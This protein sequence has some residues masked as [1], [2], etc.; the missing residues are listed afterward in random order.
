MKKWYADIIVDI[1]Q[2][3]LDRTFQYE[4]PQNLLG[5]IKT[6]TKVEVPFGK[7]SRTISGY[8]IGISDK[9][10]IEESK[11][12]PVSKIWEKGIEIESKLIGLAGWMSREY[13][14][15]MNQALKTVLP[16]KEKK[17]QKETRTI[18]L[19]IEPEEAK[20]LLEE[21][22]RKHYKAKARLLEA[23][24]LKGVLSY[25]EAT[26][27][28]KL[29]SAGIKKIEES[30]I[31]Q[32][33]KQKVYR[34]PV[35][36]KETKTVQKQLNEEQD[37]A[38]LE[39]L[40]EWES[41]FHRPVLLYGVTGSGKTEV[42]MKLIETI[43]REGKQAI[44]LIPEIALTYQT[45]ERFRAR[46]GECVSF[47]H[48]R[49]SAGERYDQMERAKNGEISIIVGPRSALFTPFPN[50]GLIVIDEEQESSYKSEKTPCYHARETAIERAR[51][52]KANVVMGSATPTIESYERARKG[53]YLLVTLKSRY[54]NQVMPD[55]TIVNLAEELK[56]GNRS[57]FSQSL[58][59]KIKERLEKKQQVMLFLNRRGYTGFVSCRACGHVMKCPHCDVSL[60]S[61]RNGKLICHYCGYTIPNVKECPSCGSPYIGGFKAGT[62]QIE[63]Q[64]HLF[65]PKARILRMDADTTR[66]KDDHEKILSA[67]LAQEADILIGT[68]MIVKGHDF[69]NVTLVGV[70]AADLSLNVGDY[71]ASERTFQ[72]LTQAVGRAGRGR[73]AGEAVIQ[74]Y[75]PEHY[76]IVTSA[77]Q[78][79]EQFFEQ[80][81]VY[82]SLMGYPPAKSML[83]ISGSSAEEALLL[84]G[85]TYCRK[86]IESIYK[87]NDLLIVG[88]APQSI[89]KI[90]DMYR[91]V[92]HLRH[93]NKEILIKIME[94][95]ERYIQI[96][97][98][99]EKIYIQFDMN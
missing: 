16:V 34:D 26:G 17:Q 3:K 42:Y 14:C 71:R 93:G 87:K 55:V 31:I 12:K 18:C 88:P 54:Q 72:L 92:L 50:L 27:N 48:S 29:S 9:P 98:G 64:A 86:Y 23:L 35:H 61:H 80:E 78:N 6:G 45:V 19:K 43:L 79:Y 4:I 28:L 5:I 33:E 1:S 77:R 37:R 70:I 53:E 75:Q 66:R 60:T 52:E 20:A 24:L 40:E 65:F 67:F 57:V 85:L 96:N 51:Q 13:G 63:E 44:V 83:T 21:W 59:E 91:M 41:P 47:L 46:F 2:E 68:Q 89:S 62:Q 22:E 58:Q 76:S 39:I 10:K 73:F 8:V 36:R 74:T 56:A 97:K 38:V 11:I 49:L 81:I 30:G 25:T 82:R 99:F 32:I 84:E 69:P 15:T 7:G 94:R 90:Q 95:L